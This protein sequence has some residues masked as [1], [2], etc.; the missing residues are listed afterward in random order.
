[1]KT[2]RSS[3]GNIEVQSDV[4]GL[5]ALAIIFTWLS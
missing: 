2:D 3:E 4:V 5:L 1:M